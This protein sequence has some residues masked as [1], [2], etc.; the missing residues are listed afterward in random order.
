MALFESIPQVAILGARGIGQ[1][2]ARLFQKSGANICAILG[3]SM[4]TAQQTAE[5][6]HKSIGISPKP[7]DKLE[8]LIKETQ[9]DALSICTPAEF[10]FEQILTAFDQGLAVFCEKPL[11]WKKNLNPD[12][13]EAQINLLNEHQDRCLFLNT[14]NAY[15]MESVLEKTGKP[16]II[17][18]FS[19]KFYTQGPHEG[20]DIA[21]DLLPHGFSL[22]ISLLGYKNIFGVL[23]EVE[24]DSYQCK[25]NYGDCKVFFEFKEIIDGQKH[26][27]FSINDR[28]FTRGQ[29]GKG[30][31]YR[32]FLNDQLTGATIETEDPF[33][34]YISRFLS[35]LNSGNKSELDKF[36]EGAFNL[37]MMSQI[38]FGDLYESH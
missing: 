9:P 35:G 26:L 12:L 33:Q 15:F 19:F 22:L 14:C 11:F 10:H 8:S 31:T 17:K 36:T 4:R 27:S 5:L 32:V 30:E 2:H 34:V 21:V 37:R 24:V 23:E 18:S 28:E 38:Y 29:E 7:F 13:L 20:K 25:F 6:L 16:S 3:S 1:V